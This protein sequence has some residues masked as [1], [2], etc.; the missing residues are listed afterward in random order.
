M[1]QYLS[2]FQETTKVNDYFISI[3]DSLI[4]KLVDTGYISSLDK[5]KFINRLEENINVLSIGSNDPLDYKTGYYDAFKK[6]IYIKD[7]LNVPSCYLRLLYVLTT[8]EIEKDV[9]NTGYLVTKMSTKNYKVIH[10]NYA[11]NRGVTANLA[12]KL[13]NLLNYN[14]SLVPTNKT[15]SH[16]F[17][18]FEIETSNDIYSIE[19]KIISELCFALNIDEDLLYAGLFTKNPRRYLER[20]FNK[21]KFV[22]S[23]E[24]IKLFDKLSITYSNY[25]KLLF[26]SNK[27]NTNHIEI[28]KNI[29]ADDISSLKK[30]KLLIEEKIRTTI[31]SLDIDKH[32]KTKEIENIEMFENE[33]NAGFSA[34]LLEVIDKLEAR[35]KKYIINIQNILAE[36][37]INVNASLSS[38]QYA[39]KLK[40]FNDILVYKNEAVSKKITETV[41]FKLLPVS[42]ITAMNIIEKI[43]YSLI[44]NIL[45]ERK[46][47]EISNTLSFKLIPDLV[48]ESNG[49]ALVL[50]SANKSFAKL[51]KVNELNKPLNNL[52][53]E[54]EDI[55]LDNLK[56]VL[57][58]DFSN[59]YYAN[60]EKLYTA[61]RINFEQFS[62]VALDNIYIFEY[63]KE[64]YMIVY[65]NHKPY[66]IK[67]SYKK[68]NFDFEIL[69]LS[70]DYSLFDKLKQSKSV[71]TSTLP[72]IYKK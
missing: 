44:L 30:Q 20:I 41:L 67:Y 56:Y 53:K 24:F 18:G 22:K 49:T 17:L 66:L 2:N 33:I 55:V 32:L 61:L 19:G 31:N 21:K 3:I 63:N 9:F 69:N 51:V 27:L 64:G 48:D 52:T 7:D 37:M 46:Y 28:K 29:L 34:N 26:L 59:M 10:E 35:L 11:F 5:S 54:T 42:E 23:E 6:N 13:S 65:T 14:I 25:N 16:N 47:T 57:N 71:N 1:K 45:S 43:K 70:E 68:S 50:L 36:T 8:R 4:T 12:C 58:S 62:N 40:R 15:Y 39:S 60:V 72:I 38:Y